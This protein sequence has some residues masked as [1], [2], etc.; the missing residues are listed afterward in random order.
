MAVLDLVRHE[1]WHVRLQC[2]AFL[3]FVACLVGDTSTFVF[4]MK[5][6]VKVALSCFT[7]EAGLTVVCRSF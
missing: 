7:V 6:V 4:V 3:W 2:R 1:V 5:I